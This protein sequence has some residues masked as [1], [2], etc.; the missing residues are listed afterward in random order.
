P[1]QLLEQLADVALV[2]A[3]AELLLDHP[4]DAGTGPDLPP[5]PVCLRAMP[6]ELGDEALLSDGELGRRARAGVGAQALRPAVAGTCEPAGNAPGGDAQSLGNV[7]AGPTSTLQ[8]QRT[9]PPPLQAVSRQEIRGLHPDILPRHGGPSLRG[10]Q[11][12]AA[13]VPD[14]GESANGT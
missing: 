11:Y 10:G 12:V 5:E 1:A 9:E 13:Y 2:V 14:V 8:V 3:D 7:P 4:G 6:K